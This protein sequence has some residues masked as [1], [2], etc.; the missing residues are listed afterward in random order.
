[1]TSVADGMNPNPCS[2][3]SYSASAITKRGEGLSKMTNATEEG[4]ILKERNGGRVTNSSMIQV[5]GNSRDRTMRAIR[6]TG[7]GKT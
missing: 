4:I 3:V 5:T 1:M 7:A 6:L 2:R